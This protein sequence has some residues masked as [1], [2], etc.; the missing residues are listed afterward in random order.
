MVRAYLFTIAIFLRY[1]L[2]LRLGG[3]KYNPCMGRSLSKTNK[4]KHCHQ[5]DEFAHCEIGALYTLGCGSVI[6]VTEGYVTRLRMQKQRQHGSLI[7]VHSVY[8][9][10]RAYYPTFIQ[11]LLLHE[12]QSPSKGNLDSSTTAKRHVCCIRCDQ[13]SRNQYGRFRNESSEACSRR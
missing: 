1:L 12:P 9:N 13:E 4:N 3:P 2:Y 8:I 5:V 7:R 10:A 6:A 11:I